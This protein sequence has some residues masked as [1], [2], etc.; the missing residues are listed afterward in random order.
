[1]RKK[2]KKR[3]NKTNQ[4]VSLEKLAAKIK[5]STDPNVISKVNQNGTRKSNINKLILF[6][7]IFIVIFDKFK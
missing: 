7:K 4:P 3:V 6:H 2:R 5:R 1:M